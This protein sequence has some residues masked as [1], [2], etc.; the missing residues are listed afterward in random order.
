[1]PQWT[2]QF[3]SF[4][5]KSLWGL[6]GVQMGALV[7]ASCVSLLVENLK[8]DNINSGTYRVLSVCNLHKA[9]SDPHHQPVS[10][11]TWAQM[12]KKSSGGRETDPGGR[13]CSDWLWSQSPGGT[14]EKGKD[15]H[16]IDEEMFR[17]WCRGVLGPAGARSQDLTMTF[18][19]IF[20]VR[21]M[22][23]W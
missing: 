16:G 19:K 11:L 7:L 15:G 23:R 18:F 17:F 13:P 10:Y 1:M 2:G 8:R 4:S 6:V 22:A 14:R 21:L 3:V 12:S 5:L 20:V 9:F